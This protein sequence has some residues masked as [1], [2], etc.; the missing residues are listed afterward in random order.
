M[1][2]TVRRRRWGW[3]LTTL[4]VLAAVYGVVGGFD[5]DSQRFR[6]LPILGFEPLRSLSAAQ[7]LCLSA[8]IAALIYGLWGGVTL[9][10]DK[11]EGSPGRDDTVEHGQSLQARAASEA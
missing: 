4:L 8:S 9:R 1:S 3:L 11:R 2:H 5:P 6:F 10:Q 7:L